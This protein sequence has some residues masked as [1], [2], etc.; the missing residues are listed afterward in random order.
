MVLKILV[1]IYGLLLWTFLESSQ[2]Y[3]SKNTKIITTGA[4]GAKLW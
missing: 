1:L 4:K 3:L 2:R